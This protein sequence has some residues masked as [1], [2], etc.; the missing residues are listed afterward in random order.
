M[1][2]PHCGSDSAKVSEAPEG[3]IVECLDC[4]IRTEPCFSTGAARNTW[5]TEYYRSVLADLDELKSDNETL[6]DEA[7]DREAEISDLED[8]IESLETE[9]EELQAEN[10]RL[11]D[12]LDTILQD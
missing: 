3:W 6:T 12:R 7:E 4:K 9:L 8:K 10:E 2:C 5:E 11:R 1:I